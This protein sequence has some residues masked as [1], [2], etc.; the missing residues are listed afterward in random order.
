MGA[1]PAISSRS[2][3]GS[4]TAIV[5]NSEELQELGGTDDRL[6]LTGLLDQWLLSDLGSPL[7]SRRTRAAA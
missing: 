4:D 2:L 1:G 6:R 5:F 7:A 3:I